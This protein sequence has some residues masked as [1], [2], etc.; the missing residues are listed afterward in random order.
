MSVSDEPATE[1]DIAACF[2]L[3]LGRPPSDEEWIGHC[4]L[5]GQPVGAVV[6]AY[7]ESKEHVR[8]V[9]RDGSP[10]GGL[11]L[12]Q[13]DGFK[14]YTDDT[15]LAVGRH[16]AGGVYEPEIAAQLQAHLQPGMTMLDIGANIGLFTMLGASLVGPDGH[17]LAVEPNPDNVRQIEAS[18]RANGF[19]QVSIA[20]CAVG[21]SVG[22]LALEST[23]SNGMTSEPGDSVQALFEAKLVPSLPLARLLPDRRI[24]FIK[25]DCEGAEYTAL[26]SIQAVLQRDRPVIVSEFNPRLLQPN[27]GVS[28]AEYLRLL[29]GLGYQMAVIK[30]DAVVPCADGAAV[31]AMQEQNAPHHIDILL[32]PGA[33]RR[34]WRSGR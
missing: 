18:R 2:R 16:V 7:L 23:Y 26:S 32:T 22:L 8:L 24:D 6:R 13:K 31:L 3:L 1:A 25:I 17:V 29:S 12:T 20:A 33:A 11:R 30:P 5:L 14:L 4:T 27:S 28:G 9:Q 19:G 15:D 10:E 21:R 34:W